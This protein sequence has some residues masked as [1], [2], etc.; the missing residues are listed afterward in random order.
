M[1][2]SDTEIIF[3]SFSGSMNIRHISVPLVTERYEKISELDCRHGK[4]ERR[5][6]YYVILRRVH[7]TIVAVEKQ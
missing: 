5:R 3:V 1:V 6:K 2:F 4:Q 7:E